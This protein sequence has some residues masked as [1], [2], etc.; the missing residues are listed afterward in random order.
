MG[1]SGA[2]AVPLPGPVPIGEDVA[3]GPL[4]DGQ[5]LLA[6]G[7]EDGAVRLSYLS[8]ASPMPG[9]KIRR[10]SSGRST[11]RRFRSHWGWDW[12]VAFG[13]LPDGQL[14]LARGGEDCAVRL[15][16]PA[17]ARWA[18]RSVATPPG[19]R[20]LAP[21]A[22]PDGRPLL[23]RGGFGPTE[24]LQVRCHR[25]RGPAPRS[26]Q[27]GHAPRSPPHLRRAAPPGRHGHLCHRAP[28]G[29]KSVETTQIY[30]HADLSIK[31]R[32]IR[33]NS[34]LGI[35]RRSRSWGTTHPYT[36]GAPGPGEPRIGT[37]AA[38]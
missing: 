29:H 18:S 34:V 6:S 37:N 19:V 9:Q 10:R 14:L 31:E 23:A 26:R 32:A 11:D 25:S 7:S 3:F 38:F 4:R 17:A 1:S 22:L 36:C 13:V 2:R 27:A 24:R 30:L 12:S 33:H 35:V 16:N 15:W 28:A 8:E 21:G 5:L 20:S